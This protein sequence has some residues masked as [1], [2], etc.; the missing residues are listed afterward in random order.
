MEKRIPLA[1]WIGIAALG[2]LTLVQ[3]ASLVQLSVY[4][5]RRSD[6]LLLSK[7]KDFAEVR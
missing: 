5:Q 1:L 4:L 3:T 7:V 2:A 6:A